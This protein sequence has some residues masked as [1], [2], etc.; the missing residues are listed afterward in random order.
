M[1]RLHNPSSRA[2]IEE[3]KDRL[4][5]CLTS[6]PYTPDADGAEFEV[7][8]RLVLVVERMDQRQITRKEAE[9][10][11]AK[12][13]LHGFSFGRWLADMMDEGVYLDAASPELA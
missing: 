6:E 12:H 2:H 13:C 1:I 8:H 11:F 7:M 3:L 9:A 5:E 10:A 4:S